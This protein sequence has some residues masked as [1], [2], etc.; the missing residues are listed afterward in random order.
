MKYRRL[1]TAFWL[2][3][4]TFTCLPKQAI[5]SDQKALKSA[6]VQTLDDGVRF[7]GTKEQIDKFKKL[8]NDLAAKKESFALARKGYADKSMTIK[9]YGDAQRAF[10]KSREALREIEIQLDI[11][12]GKSLPSGR[13]IDVHYSKP[14]YQE[15]RR[16][17]NQMSFM[18]EMKWDKDKQI[19]KLKKMLDLC[20]GHPTEGHILVELGRVYS[21]SDDEKAMTYF[22]RAAQN[23]LQSD[24]WD[25]AK[26]AALKE[27]ANLYVKKKQYKKAIKTLD[28]MKISEPSRTGARASRMARE[29]NIYLLRMKFEARDKVLAEM[30]HKLRTKETY[31]EWD[32]EASCI[33]SLYTEE[34]YPQLKKTVEDALKQSSK[35]KVNQSLLKELKGHMDFWQ[36]TKDSTD[37]ML[38]Q[39]SKLSYEHHHTIIGYVNEVIDRISEFRRDEMWRARVAIDAFKYHDAKVLSPKLLKLING[40]PFKPL[41]L[42]AYCKVDSKNAANFIKEKL[43]LTANETGNIN[44]MDMRFFSYSLLLTGDPNAELL[45]KQAAKTSQQKR[46]VEW[47]FEKYR[48]PKK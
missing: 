33:I 5:S 48:K 46:A 34:Q 30:W 12:P 14:L 17:Q 7:S 40:E 29:Y 27:L 26:Q 6:K 11:I 41:A 32:S 21:Y 42:I 20:S 23:P 8:A 36:K 44:E 39:I 28:S 10:V 9:E 22:Q 16:I 15:S 35:N 1:V 3:L 38:E 43:K 24:T 18:R 4:V 19:R 47:V 25:F 13:S 2:I 37:Y 45:I 31:Y